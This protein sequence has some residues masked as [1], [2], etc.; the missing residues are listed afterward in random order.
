[1]HHILGGELAKA[2]VELHPLAQEE[3]PLFQ[4]RA[5]LPLFRQAGDVFPGLGINVEQG[6]QKGIVLQMLGTGDGP[7]AVA[8]GEPAEPKTTRCTLASAAATIVGVAAR[9][10]TSTPIDKVSV[11]RWNVS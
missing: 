1:M 11:P 8:L 5:G 6:L 9:S 4:V 3:G 2:V 7:E 10:K